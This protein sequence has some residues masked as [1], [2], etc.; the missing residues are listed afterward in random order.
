M[1]N[2]KNFQSTDYYFAIQKYE[3]RIK[4]NVEQERQ[5]EIFNFPCTY[6]PSP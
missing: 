1:Q 3:V 5:R 6:C 4:S 2:L